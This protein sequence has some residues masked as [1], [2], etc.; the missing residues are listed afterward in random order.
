MLSSDGLKEGTQWP[1]TEKRI[2]NSNPLNF[3]W[4]LI[5]F[6]MLYFTHA[7]SLSD[8]LYISPFLFYFQPYDSL[9]PTPLHFSNSVTLISFAGGH[10]EKDHRILQIKQS[11]GRP[12]GNISLVHHIFHFCLICYPPHALATSSMTTFRYSHSNLH[13]FSVW[14]FMPFIL[15]PP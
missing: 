12:S 8:Y 3:Y 7:L 11:I 14:L 2:T 13:L 10:Y 4:N 6:I 9:R 5:I 15:F 1:E